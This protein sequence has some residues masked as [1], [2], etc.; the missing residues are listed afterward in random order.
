MDHAEAVAKVEVVL[1]EFIDWEEDIVDIAAT[2]V[3]TICPDMD[4]WDDMETFV[5]DIILLSLSSKN[6]PHET[7]ERVV[8]S[9]ENRQ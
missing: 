4:E 6:N 1:K 7:A 5:G 3:N 8:S 2:I 9:V